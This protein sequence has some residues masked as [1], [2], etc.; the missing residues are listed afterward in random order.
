MFAAR[1]ESRSWEAASV[2]SLPRSQ[3][4]AGANTFRDPQGDHV[5]AKLDAPDPVS[6]IRRQAPGEGS[7]SGTRSL[8]IL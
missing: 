1:S 3:P 2:D 7:G 5:P 4:I 6:G 8:D